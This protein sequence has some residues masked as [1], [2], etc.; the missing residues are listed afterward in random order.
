MFNIFQMRLGFNKWGR[1]KVYSKNSCK[2]KTQNKCV[3]VCLNVNLYNQT[4]VGR[5]ATLKLS[6]SNNYLQKFTYE[7]YLTTWTEWG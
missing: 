3:C 2:K 6:V 7:V 5:A 1:V 4:I